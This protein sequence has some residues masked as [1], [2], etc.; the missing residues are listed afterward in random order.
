MTSA[1]C[2]LLFYSH[3][4]LR[5]PY[6]TLFPYTTLFR[7]DFVGA[8]GLVQCAQHIAADATVTVDGDLYGHGAGSSGIVRVAGQDGDRKSTRL[9]SSHVAISY[10]VFCL[11][12][13][14]MHDFKDLTQ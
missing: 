2:L 10:A 3:M 12:K 4:I 6:S 1:L 13:N 11:K 8:V 9:N 14:I 7:S 5:P